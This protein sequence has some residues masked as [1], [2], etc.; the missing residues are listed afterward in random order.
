MFAEGNRLRDNRRSF[1]ANRRCPMLG[2]GGSVG[3]DVAEGGSLLLCFVAVKV[4]PCAEGV[5]PLLAMPCPSASVSVWSSIG[6][7]NS[8]KVL[9]ATVRGDVHDIGKNI[10]SVV[11]SCNNFEVCVRATAGGAVVAVLCLC[12]EASLQ[13]V[14]SKHRLMGVGGHEGGHCRPPAPPPREQQWAEFC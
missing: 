6:S 8:A 13:I 10:V 14:G 3:S 2:D 12:G 9:F 7:Q 5:G 4:S 11:M 1:A